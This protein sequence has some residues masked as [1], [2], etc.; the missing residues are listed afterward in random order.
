[1]LKINDI[2]KLC[3]K[4]AYLKLSHIIPKFIFR[5]LKETSA[6]GYLRFGQNPDV[7]VQD[8]FKEF[9]L[10]GECENLLNKWETEFANKLFYPLVQGKKSSF[11]YKGWLLKFAVSLS[12]RSLI[13]I[14]T[15]GLSH[16]TDNQQKQSGIALEVWRKFL[17]GDIQHLDKYQQHVI[18]V[19]I[20]SDSSMPNLP[21]NINRYFLRSINI[22]P[23]ASES[24]ALVYIKIPYFIFIGGIQFDPKQWV[25]TTIQTHKGM[26]EKNKCTVPQG[27]GD[28]IIDKA[29]KVGNIPK[30]IS[31]KQKNKIEKAILNDLDRV[32]KSETFR[33]MHADVKLFGNDV[34]K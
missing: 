8:G 3:H 10:C 23:I 26:I 5:W 12:W 25:N 28:Y 14:K 33:A 27:F 22:D 29:M 32:S 16:F 30:N 1:M 17:L 6:T 31:E 11:E 15:I 24:Q 4:K 18:P 20:V 9:W 19:G 21:K 34:F 7:R 13:L 2:C